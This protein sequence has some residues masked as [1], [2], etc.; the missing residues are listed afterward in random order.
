MDIKDILTEINLDTFEQFVFEYQG[1]N[2]QMRMIGNVSI[3]NSI[4]DWKDF[5][6]LNIKTMIS[7]MQKDNLD[8]IDMGMCFPDKG[9]GYN[10]EVKISN[11][12]ET[13][14]A[15]I[16]ENVIPKRGRRNGKD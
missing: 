9:I 14:S 2:V 1:K 11:K 12:V 3:L 5:V 16:V 6:A 13:I 10:V 15:P 8:N 7:I 4:G